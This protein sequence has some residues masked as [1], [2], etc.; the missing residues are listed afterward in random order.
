MVS[1]VPSVAAVVGAD[2]QYV[3]TLFATAVADWRAAGV[4]VVG[5]IAETHDLA[6]RS[7]SARI[8]ARYR[9]RKTIFDLSGN[10]TERYVMSSRCERRQRGLGQSDASDPDR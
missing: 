10:S 8:P 7:C 1:A 3:Q 5:V 4:K 6:D 2:S 9:D